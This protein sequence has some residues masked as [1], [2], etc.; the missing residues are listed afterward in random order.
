MIRRP[1]RSTH[2]PFTT[3]FR[4]DH[5]LDGNAILIAYI[6][7]IFYFFVY[8]LVLVLTEKINQTLETVFHHISKHLKVHQNYSAVHHIFN[9]FLNVWKYDETLSQ[10]FDIL[11][12]QFKD[13]SRTTPIHFLINLLSNL[14][15]CLKCGF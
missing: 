6:F 12:D 13:Y 10:V 14:P 9:F 1:P 4:S 3:L 2:F 8:S 15:V 7:T 5:G 11:L